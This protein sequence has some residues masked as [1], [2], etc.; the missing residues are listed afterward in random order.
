MKQ[1]SGLPNN[2]PL[3]LVEMFRNKGMVEAVSKQLNFVI[4]TLLDTLMSKA[5]IL[6]P[7][8]LYL[9]AM[10]NEGYIGVVTTDYISKGIDYCTFC[11]ATK[12]LN[13]IR[14]GWSKYAN[15]TSVGLAAAYV[16]SNQS[17]FN[18]VPQ[19]LQVMIQNSAKVF[20]TEITTAL[21]FNSNGI[22]NMQQYYPNYQP[23]PGFGNNTQN[24][25]AQ[26]M[27]QVPY[28]QQ[29]AMMQP[30]MMPYGVPQMP[31]GQPQMLP[32]NMQSQQLAAMMQNPQFAAM[33]Q[34]NPQQAMA[35]MNNPMLRPNTVMP[36]QGMMQQPMPVGGIINNGYQ[37]P[38]SN[39]HVG[40]T[41]GSA[42]GKASSPAQNVPVVNNQQGQWNNGM[43][44]T[45]QQQPPQ[46]QV[47]NQQGVHHQVTQATVVMGNGQQPQPINFQ[48]QQPV[49][50]QA[51]QQTPQPSVVAQVPPYAQVNSPAVNKPVSDYVV[52]TNDMSFDIGG[53]RIP[54]IYNSDTEILKVQLNED[55]VAVNERIEKAEMKYAEHESQRL[56]PVRTRTETRASTSASE[57]NQQLEMA[58]NYVTYKS[59]IE[60]IENDKKSAGEEDITA[61]S[62]SIIIELGT[63][64]LRIETPAIT[65]DKSGIFPVISEY[66]NS[67][68]IKVDIKTRATN[69]DAMLASMFSITRELADSVI[70]LN[71]S[72]NLTDYVTILNF[73]SSQDH[74][75]HIWAWIHDQV[76]NAINKFLKNYHGLS[77]SI[78]SVVNDYE[79]ML[80]VIAEEYGQ[81]L[82]TQVYMS[83]HHMLTS[84]ILRVYDHDEYP[85]QVGEG[86]IYLGTS[87]RVITLPIL[88]CRI[89]YCAPG[90]VGI[91][92]RN[93]YTVLTK[94]VEDS[95]KDCEDIHSL[96]IITLDND[97]IEISTTS[98]D[99]NYI[100]SRG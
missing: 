90:K 73:I 78:D 37:Q 79:D 64:A 6:V 35:M 38:V 31:Y 68:N 88:S 23:M 18:R 54:Q 72:H 9:E 89:P 15:D 48:A 87:Y 70:K 41:R 96:L 28:G 74:P 61:D 11:V 5:A 66:I 22:Y 47:N 36:Q 99:G 17:V 14:Q 55:G 26:P 59:V 95:L 32:P 24:F 43:Q 85:N 27:Q 51:V 93:R 86:C 3:E 19:E 63:A 56:M 16:L 49:Q 84:T 44:P 62:A 7:C 76:L 2:P 52:A 30:Q 1:L 20:E 40:A 46:Q 98:I 80:K 91:I 100:M 71:N 13:N 8:Q 33:M 10:H 97:I 75:N 4:G 53:R 50:Q 58:S 34:Q 57:I 81:D 69:V 12:E 82:S 21:N 67:N 65:F 83:L 39:A 60:R 45:A 25:I 94:L 29:P 77:I 42:F 92:D